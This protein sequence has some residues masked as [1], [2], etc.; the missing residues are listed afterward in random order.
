MSSWPELGAGAVTAA[1][2]AF[3][4][5]S[6]QAQPAALAARH[7]GLGRP[8]TAAEIAAWDIDVRPDFKGL[9]RGTGTVT[10][11]MDVWE[12][13]CAA[14]HG[15]FG[16]SNQ[17][18]SP[19][20]GGTTAKDMQSGNVA[21]LRDGSFPGRT[22]LMKLSSLSTLWDYIHRAMPWTAPKSLSVDEVYAVTAYILNLGGIVP[23][24]FT[25]SD[26]NMADVQHLLPNRNGS[27]T[28]HALWPDARPGR[29]KPDVAAV[30]CMRNCA[31]ES[32]IVSYVPDFARDAHGNLANQNRSVGPQRG[33]NTGTPAAAAVTGSAGYALAQQHAC[34]ACHGLDQRVVGPG[35]QEIA[36]KY[37]GQAG[38]LVYLAGKVKSGGV[39][40][41][42]NIAMPAQALSDADASAIA[43]WLSSGAKRH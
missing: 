3:A 36:N 42:G 21:S 20:V 9:P 32:K 15:V 19:I 14:C 13:K 41:W 4:V 16:E 25:L 5:A 39:G 29:H 17:F 31:T 27:T 12:S 26:R 24:S 23:D 22:T 38:A 34:S 35:F 6:V 28:A 37:T 7:P 10:K 2:L 30:A 43:A 33:A 8:A 1:L 11:G 40:I 18:F